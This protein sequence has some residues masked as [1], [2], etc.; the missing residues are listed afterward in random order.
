MHTITRVIGTAAVTAALGLGVSA[1]P[2]SAATP[3]SVSMS[4]QGSWFHNDHRR[5]DRDNRWDSNH[6]NW[7][8][9]CDN[10]DHHDNGDHRFW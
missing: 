6:W 7:K 9:R 4:D 8:D 2:A 5:C 1:L 3:T 10:R